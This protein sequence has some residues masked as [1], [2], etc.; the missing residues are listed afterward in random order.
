MDYKLQINRQVER[1]RHADTMR[2]GLSWCKRQK[3]LGFVF[4]G[5]KSSYPIT[6]KNFTENVRWILWPWNGCF[7][8]TRNDCNHRRHKAPQPTFPESSRTILF[9]QCV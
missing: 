5:V 7:T 9:Q 3:L 2:C 4:G 8:V 1:H 6:E